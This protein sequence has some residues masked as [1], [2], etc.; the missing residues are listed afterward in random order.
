VLASEAAI[1][2]MLAKGMKEPEILAEIAR[3]NGVTQDK[4]LQPTVT[5]PIGGFGKS[6]EGA[7]ILSPRQ[8]EAN[9]ETG[10]NDANDIAETKKQLSAFR[11][12]NE[13]LR[14]MEAI[15]LSGQHT[16]GALHETLNKVGG[17]FN[18]LDPDNSLAKAAGNDAAYFGNMMNL[19]R[20]KIQALGSGTAVSNLD[21]IVTQKSVGDL[22]NTPQGNLKVLGLMKL[23]NATM[24]ELGQNKIDHYDNSNETLKGYKSRAEPTHALRATRH[25]YGDGVIMSYDVQSKS[26]W[27]EEQKRRNAGKEIPKDILDREWKRFA[28]DSVRMVFK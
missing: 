20:D 24:A 27:I 9:K 12:A 2:E 25:A 23:F 19:V 22:R 14:P 5:Q 26:E 17:Y 13:N 21:L 1:Q 15:L 6:G 10:K 28:D 7:S 4:V 3:M 18:Y 8:L 11:S 16:S